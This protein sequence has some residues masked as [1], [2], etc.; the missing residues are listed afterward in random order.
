MNDMKT[1]KVP[2]DAIEQCIQKLRKKFTSKICT[3]TFERNYTLIYLG[4]G[5][6]S[7]LGVLD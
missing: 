7:R 1:E 2:A 4:A 6:S 5:T 3:S